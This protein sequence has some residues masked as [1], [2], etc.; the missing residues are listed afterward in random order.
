MSASGNFNHKR[1][2]MDNH[3]IVKQITAAKPKSVFLDGKPR[4][5]RGFKFGKNNQVGIKDQGLQNI[6]R[7]AF[8]TETSDEVIEM[9]DSC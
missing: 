6:R 4:V 8:A 2:S 7:A 3:D 5:D 1:G 9:I